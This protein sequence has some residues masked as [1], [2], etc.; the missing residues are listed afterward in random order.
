MMHRA[1]TDRLGMQ[2]PVSIAPPRSRFRAA[3]YGLAPGAAMIA[4]AMGFRLDPQSASAFSGQPL[5]QTSFT[6]T[7]VNQHNTTP[8][9]LPSQQ[10][11]LQHGAAPGDQGAGTEP[12]PR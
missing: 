7:P 10:H 9:P 11:P 1:G 3:I 12:A 8:Q 6:N 5:D 2:Q 4:I